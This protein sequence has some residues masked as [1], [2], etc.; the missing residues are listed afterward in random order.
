M[1]SELYSEFNLF[2][3]RIKNYFLASAKQKVSFYKLFKNSKNKSHLP[4]S[5]HQRVTEILIKG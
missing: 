5:S 3:M 1:K 4:S 2:D